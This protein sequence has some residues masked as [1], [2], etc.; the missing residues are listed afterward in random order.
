[1]IPFKN[2]YIIEKLITERNSHEQIFLQKMFGQKIEKND[3]Q[4]YLE[5]I[6]DHKWY[7]SERLGRDTGLPVAALDFVTN[8]EP[9]PIANRR[10]K[11]I[12]SGKLQR[13]IRF[14]LTA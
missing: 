2:D 8:I 3:A 9:L 13:T 1:M 14:G 5:R 12:T 10:R 7:L 11:N 6:L 4:R